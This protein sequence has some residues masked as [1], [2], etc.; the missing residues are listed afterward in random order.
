M[1]VDEHKIRYSSHTVVYSLKRK[2][3]KNINISVSP[4]GK[5]TVSAPLDASF[6][7]I[8]DVVFNK[9]SWILKQQQRFIK[10]QAEPTIEKDY[11]S[12]E[13]F[14]YL[15]KQYRL[16]V[17]ETTI[18]ESIYLK[19]NYINMMVKNKKNR[20]HKEILLTNWFRSRAKEIF[21]QALDRVYPLV[22]NKID[23]K[24]GIDF[25]V[26]RKRW[27]SA[28]RM[29]N[30]ILLNYDLIKAPKQCIEYV[31]LHELIH[32]KHKRHN[33]QFYDSLTVLMPDWKQ[34]K[35]ILDEEVVLYL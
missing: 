17:Y 6:E 24:P 12:G 27:G 13:S 5:V 33:K 7:D 31:V 34:R 15:G 35:K 30:K 16:Q 21:N 8:H 3:I 25:K 26:M 1:D 14:K 9:A 32:F 19:D 10:T 22:R 23:G 28:L 18:Q 4:E 2:N 11:V 29:K 20:R